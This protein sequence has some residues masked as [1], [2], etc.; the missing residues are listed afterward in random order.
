MSPPRDKGIKS[1]SKFV[2]S[3]AADCALTGTDSVKQN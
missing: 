2:D 3:D 1:G